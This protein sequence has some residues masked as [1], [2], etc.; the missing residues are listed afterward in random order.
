MRLVFSVYFCQRELNRRGFKKIVKTIQPLV[1]TNTAVPTGQLC[2]S[3]MRPKWTS[4]PTETDTHVFTFCLHR[5]PLC[6]MTSRCSGKLPTI[7]EQ[8]AQYQILDPICLFEQNKHGEIGRYHSIAEHS[9]V[10]VHLNRV[11]LGILGLPMPPLHLTQS[12]ELRTSKEF[13]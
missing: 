8:L 9:N 7:L 1:L 5:C 10:F 11:A 2:V 13:A 6:S 12:Y 3:T 4:A